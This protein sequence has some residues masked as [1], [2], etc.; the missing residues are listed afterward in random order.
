MSCSRAVAVEEPI[1]GASCADPEAERS[2]KE[3]TAA[4]EREFFNRTGVSAGSL[5][6]DVVDLM[7]ATDSGTFREFQQ[8]LADLPEDEAP[9][10]ASEAR[11]FLV[12]QGLNPNASALNRIVMKILTG[13]Y[14]G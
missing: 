1:G 6:G 3:N 14:G 2:D 8:A 10:S 7:D 11:E 13:A 4:L 9:V 5:G 12:Q